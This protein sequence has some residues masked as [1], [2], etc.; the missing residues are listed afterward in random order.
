MAMVCLLVDGHSCSGKSFARGSVKGMCRLLVVLMVGVWWVLMP[1]TASSEEMS[2]RTFYDFDNATDDDR[3]FQEFL[4]QKLEGRFRD[5]RLVVSSS[6][7][8]KDGRLQVFTLATQPGTVQTVYADITATFDAVPDNRD[9]SLLAG[10][11][12]IM[13]SGEGNS[14]FVFTV[15]PEGKACV[16]AFANGKVGSQSVS[17]IEG[18]RPGQTVRLAAREN[19]QGA[20]FMVNGHKIATLSDS[21][22]PGRGVGL[23]YFGAGDFTFDNFGLNSEGKLPD[24]NPVSQPKKEIKEPNASFPDVNSLFDE[25]KREAESG[26][27]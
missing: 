15:T 25:A 26:G 19:G 8:E 21:G 6:L 27:P 5:G 2:I 3:R 18:Y 4:Q 23:I 1:A 10:P 24:A 9:Q 20:T 12:L 14:M 17:P 11:G 13:R 7:G 22:I 16:A